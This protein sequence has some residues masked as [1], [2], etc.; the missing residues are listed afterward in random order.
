MLIFN[1]LEFQNRTMKAMISF[2]VGLFFFSFNLVEAQNTLY[3]MGDSTMADYENNYDPGISYEEKR[4]PLTGWGQVFHPYLHPDS[5]KLL[6]GFFPK[7]KSYRLVNKARGGR[8][9]RTFFQEGRWRSIYDQLKK[10]D[11]VLIQFGHNDA[12]KSK[13]ERYV[14]VA[15]F[16][17]FLRLYTQLIRAK[18]A[19]PILV[20]PVARN[21]PW[22]NGVLENVHGEY[23]KAVKEIALQTKTP[24]ID[25]NKR[26]RAFFT[27]EG[28]EKTSSMYFMNI[29]KG[30]YKAYP[31]GLKDNT[32]FQTLGAK[33]IAQL[34]FDELKVLANEME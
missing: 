28:K 31:L 22:R 1:G 14:P 9:T 30:R 27:K 15:G 33:K 2:F 8:S 20:T 3:L 11:I 4:Y 25:L 32:H 6:K 19:L 17:E 18:G 26:S 21:Y 10:K 24:L 5:L 29:E 12:A 23:D 7:H 13:S 16:K 34:V